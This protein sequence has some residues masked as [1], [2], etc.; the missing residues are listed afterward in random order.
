VRLP[1]QSAR[2]EISIQAIEGDTGRAAALGPV[3]R[4]RRPTLFPA[5]ANARSQAFAL[6]VAGGDDVLQSSL[7]KILR[8][9]PDEPK[10]KR[11]LFSHVLLS[12]YGGLTARGLMA[13]RSHA[14][15]GIEQG[16]QNVRTVTGQR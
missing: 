10:C 14:I 5:V 3:R 8:P 6:K 2:L 4:I 13:T 11:R 9:I 1:S 15:S 16:A 12:I 7:R